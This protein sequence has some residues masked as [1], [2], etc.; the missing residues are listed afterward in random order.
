MCHSPGEI[1]NSSHGFSQ[2]YPLVTKT[3]HSVGIIEA[4]EQKE[5]SCNGILPLK[6]AGKNEFPVPK[7]NYPV[8]IINGQ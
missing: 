4:R 5:E 8:Q 3:S 1:F 6:A 7:S 2:S